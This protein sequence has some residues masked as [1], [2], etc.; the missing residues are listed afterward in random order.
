MLPLQ[1]R[2][3]PAQPLARPRRTWRDRNLATLSWAAPN[4]T[5]MSWGRDYGHYVGHTA[6]VGA[7]LGAHRAGEVESTASGEPELLWR[8]RPF[9]SRRDAARFEAAMKSLRDQQAERFREITGL[10][11]VPFDDGWSD[12]PRWHKVSRPA[13][14]RRGGCGLFGLVVITMAARNIDPGT[15]ALVGV[16]PMA[17]YHAD[18]VIRRANVITIDPEPAP[19]LRGCDAGRPFHRRRQRLGPGDANR[20]EHQDR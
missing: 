17:A 16:S 3:R 9:R 12:E 4:S 10:A 11:P 1:P 20:A 6:N 8:S 2:R 14:Y 5:C 13:K 18:T 15:R 19:C 7:R